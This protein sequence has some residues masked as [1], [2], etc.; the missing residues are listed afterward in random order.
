MCVVVRYIREENRRMEIFFAYLGI[1]IE[2]G[3]K[4]RYLVVG[5]VV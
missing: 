3:D 2:F 4:F 1:L 5:L